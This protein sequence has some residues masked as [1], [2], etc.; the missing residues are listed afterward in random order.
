MHCDEECEEE[1]EEEEESE[2][3]CEEEESEED[4]EEDSEGDSTNGAEDSEQPPKANMTAQIGKESV[5]DGENNMTEDEASRKKQA[6]SV[7][8]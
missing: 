2:G 1:S 3:E 8:R 5:E 4:S 7:F 6:G